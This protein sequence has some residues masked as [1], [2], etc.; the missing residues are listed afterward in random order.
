[1]KAPNL[2][3]TESIQE[4]E[5]ELSSGHKTDHHEPVGYYRGAKIILSDGLNANDYRVVWVFRDDV[6]DQVHDAS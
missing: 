5:N 2:K 1:M 3:S 4:S 6:H